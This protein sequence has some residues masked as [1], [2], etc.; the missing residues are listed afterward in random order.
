MGAISLATAD[1]AVLT[2]ALDAAARDERGRSDAG[3]AISGEAQ[4]FVAHGGALLYRPVGRRWVSIT[5]PLGALEARRAA[6][7]AFRDAARASHRRA[8]FHDLR[9]DDVAFARSLGL[10]VEKIGEAAELDLAT[11]SLRGNK[12][13]A[14][15]RNYKKLVKANARFE[16]LP[17]EAVAAHLAD[18]EAVS[19]AWLT[20]R[21]R[22]LG[23]TLGRFDPDYLT[24]TPVACVW[25]DDRMVGF[26]SVWLSP[27]GQAASMDLMRRRPD[28]PM[29][30]MDFLFVELIGWTAAR[31]CQRFDLGLAPLAGL[32]GETGAFAR[33]GATIFEHGEAIYNFQGV[34]Q[35]KNKFA[36][37]WSPRYLA[38]DGGLGRGV[39]TL[40]DLARL[41]AGGWTAL[42]ARFKMRLARRSVA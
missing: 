32:Q 33:L 40:L 8:V 15:R 36:P 16:V 17:A 12:R 7:T 22:E 37:A 3:L 18:L 35:F 13:E 4:G 20:A 31:G 5:S 14:L 42:A 34:R 26:A 25:V 1:T 39:M 6:M 41:G 2:Q 30:A 19:E 9:P 11:F 29:G 24:R 38:F 27:D 28:A 10:R 21:G 23:G